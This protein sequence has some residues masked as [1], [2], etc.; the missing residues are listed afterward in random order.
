MRGGWRSAAGLVVFLGIGTVLGYAQESAPSPTPT[1]VAPN[2]IRALRE[3]LERLQQRLTR[4]EAGDA[5]APTPTATPTATAEPPM[6]RSSRRTPS[7]GTT[8]AAAPST[9]PIPEECG[10]VVP[11]DD[12]GIA[13]WDYLNR[14]NAAQLSK[15][16]P[17]GSARCAPEQPLAVHFHNASTRPLVV[18]LTAKGFPPDVACPDDWKPVDGGCRASQKVEGSG[19]GRITVEKLKDKLLSLPK[20]P[21]VEMSVEFFAGTE[22][23]AQPVGYFR[24]EDQKIDDRS[25]ASFSVGTRLARTSEPMVAKDTPLATYTGASI[26]HFPFEGTVA[27]RQALGDRG[28]AE[29]ELTFR[30]ASFGGA[31]DIKA[32][33]YVINAYSVRGASLSFGRFEFAKPTSG[34]AIRESGDGFRLRYR[35]VS[36]SHI[37]KRES[38]KGEPDAEDD[39]DSAWLG[40]ARNVT[41]DE[42]GVFRSYSLT[43]VYGHERAR[44]D[45]DGDG[46]HEIGDL[47][48]HQYAAGGVELALALPGDVGGTLGVHHARRWDS[49]VLPKGRGTSALLTLGRTWG[50]RENDDVH[51]TF[52]TSWQIVGR[53]GYG[54][55]NDPD[56][57][58]DE[59]YVGESEAF[60]PDRLYFKTFASVARLSE[61]G[62]GRGLSN[63]TYGNVAVTTHLNP[64]RAIAQLVTDK[65]GK[66]IESASTTLSLH[67][68]G[69]NQEVKGSHHLGT[70]LQLS[71]DIETP[72][73]VQCSVSVARFMPGGAVE[74]TFLEAPMSFAASVT[75]KLPR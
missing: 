73:G 41:L 17:D 32:S 49:D 43:A 65:Q 64:M 9:T 37:I 20:A 45:K 13:D 31:G 14:R 57:D 28:D 35:K 15:K 36:V 59:G 1:P 34:I 18:R 8:A 23:P 61:R 40:E 19:T 7:A 53:L 56:T 39:D 4:L 42:T 47:A 71:F 38:L 2:E 51:K 58:A 52:K 25:D 26:H 5:T 69:L 6:K 66:D 70:E 62:L 16:Q 10:I 3:E 67:Y 75:M 63:K 50:S 21:L 11:I 68:Y 24:F 72:K 30:Q 29:V 27:G 60:V 74:D 44:L 33:R 48:P 55:A 12:T 46:T 22:K 54:T